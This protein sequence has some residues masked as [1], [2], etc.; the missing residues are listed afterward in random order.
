[1]VFRLAPTVKGPPASYLC[2]WMGVLRA[3]AGGPGISGMPLTVTV[4][5]AVFILIT[6]VIPVPLPGNFVRG[7]SDLNLIHW[8]FI[9]YNVIQHARSTGVGLVAYLTMQCDTGNS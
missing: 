8:H 6:G 9:L 4:R 1:M 5:T 7:R 2:S 3:E